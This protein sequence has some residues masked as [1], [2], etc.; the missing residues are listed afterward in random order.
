MAEVDPMQYL[1]VD[2]GQAMKEQAK[3]L[4][5]KKWV[6]VPVAGPD[7]YVAAQVKGAAGDKVTVET[8]DGKVSRFLCFILLPAHHSAHH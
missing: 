4:D 8:Q 6:W 2:P 5:T 1:R 3:G 7:G